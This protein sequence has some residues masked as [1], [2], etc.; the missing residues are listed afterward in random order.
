M[1]P[2]WFWEL[3]ISEKFYYKLFCEKNGKTA[4][5]LRFLAQTVSRFLDNFFASNYS[6]RAT[7]PSLN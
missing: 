2:N 3:K 5:C 4:N 7:C 6:N 1:I